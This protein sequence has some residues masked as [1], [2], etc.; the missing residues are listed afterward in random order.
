MMVV[1]F[2][3]TEF[4]GVVSCGGFVLVFLVVLV[5][6]LDGVFVGWVLLDMGIC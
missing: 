2:S 1:F 6:K 4:W 5:R 3:F